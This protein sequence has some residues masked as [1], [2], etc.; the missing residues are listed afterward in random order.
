MTTHPLN[1]QPPPQSMDEELTLEPWTRVFIPVEITNKYWEYLCQGFHDATRQIE[2]GIY[3]DGE[4]IDITNFFGMLRGSTKLIPDEIFA[5][6]SGAFSGGSASY[7]YKYSDRK[8]NA[9]GAFR[10]SPSIYGFIDALFLTFEIK[11]YH[12]YW[13]ANYERF[14]LILDSNSAGE[15]QKEMT[16]CVEELMH[17]HFR[18][19]QANRSLCDTPEYIATKLRQMTALGLSIC[20]SDSLY[21]VS[22]LGNYGHKISEF[23]VSISPENGIISKCNNDFFLIRHPPVY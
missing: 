22:C 19:S 8:Q 7:Y 17:Y 14:S 13:H 11:T 5:Q 1:L 16:Q 23:Q 15:V 20:K 10:F 3:G 6:Y 4:E 21:N 18:F 9:L 2:T 12:L